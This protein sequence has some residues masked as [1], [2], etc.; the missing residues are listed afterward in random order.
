MMIIE[1]SDL[2]V[3]KDFLEKTFNSA[4]SEET[5]G[6]SVKEVCLY[7]SYTH[8]DGSQSKDVITNIEIS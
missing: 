8:E 2:A 6:G 1:K 4:N 5:G 3:V 7:L